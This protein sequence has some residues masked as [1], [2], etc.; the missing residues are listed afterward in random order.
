MLTDLLIDE[1]TLPPLPMT[2]GPSLSPLLLYDTRARLADEFAANGLA[3]FWGDQLARAK[4]AM[5]SAE[6]RHDF[7][8][9]NYIA[10]LERLIPY[11]TNLS[12]PPSPSVSPG[13]L[14]T[15]TRPPTRAPSPLAIATTSVALASAPATSPIAISPVAS[16]ESGSKGTE[17]EKSV[18]SDGESGGEDESD[19]TM[20]GVDSP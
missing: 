12:S 11:R 13:A 17:T 2:S 3:L 19:E 6:A 4:A 5:T 7:A 20:E 14:S 8:Q 18:E 15:G 10:S 16:T 9:A 1:P